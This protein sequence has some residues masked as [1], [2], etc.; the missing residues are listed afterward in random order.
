[1]KSTV[2]D[3]SLSSFKPMYCSREY[4]TSTRYSHDDLLRV[5]KSAKQNKRYKIIDFNPENIIRK[6]KLNRQGKQG[7]KQGGRTTKPQCRNP[8][9]LIYIKPTNKMSNLTE[10]NLDQSIKVTLTNIQSGKARSY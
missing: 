4:H 8:S 10:H 7:G 2:V 3:E 5:C 1:M 6:L 9:N